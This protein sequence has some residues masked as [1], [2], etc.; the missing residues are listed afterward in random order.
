RLAAVRGTWLAAALAVVADRAVMAGGVA[1]DLRPEA[2]RRQPAARDLVVVRLA[3]RELDVLRIADV[4]GVSDPDRIGAVA[5]DAQARRRR[6]ARRRRHRR[7]AHRSRRAGVARRQTDEERLPAL[8]RG[9]IGDYVGAAA[10]DRR[11]VAAGDL[12]LQRNGVAVTHDRV[13]AAELEDA[14]RLPRARGGAVGVDDSAAAV[15]GANE[16]AVVGL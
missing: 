15:L 4:V 16:M 8:N 5:G 11:D 7:R 6:G 10:A 2:R 12:G 14:E 9:A 13:A 1:A 3:A